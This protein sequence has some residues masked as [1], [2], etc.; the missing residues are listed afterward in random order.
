VNF[1]DLVEISQF[2]SVSLNRSRYQ[3]S[4]YTNL[5]YNTHTAT[6]ELIIRY[7][8]KVVFE[9]NFAITANTQQIAG[10]NNNI[11]LWNAAVTYLFMKND[12]LQLKLAINDILQSNVRRS[13]EI[14]GNSVIDYQTNNL[15]RY[16]M[17]TLTYN[18]QN[19]GQKVG[20]RQTFFN[21]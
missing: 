16:G 9:T 11:K 19:F 14:T 2:Y 3:D 7:P 5:S 6:S 15:G 13:V 4:F 1:N 21:F 18:I 17:L 20:G 10:Y 12:R 8:K